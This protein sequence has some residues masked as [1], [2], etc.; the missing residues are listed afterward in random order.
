MTRSKKKYIELTN[1]ILNGLNYDD[2][3]AVTIAEGGAMGDP[4]AIEIVNSNL[5]I[6]HTHFREIDN[7]L[8]QEKI[9][10]IKNLQIAFGEIDGLSKDWAGLYAGYGNYLFVRPEYKKPILEYINK[11]YGDT[12]MPITVE[13]YSHWYD[14]IKKSHN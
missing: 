6:Y 5:D 13:L 12:G 9:P 11:K 4:G 10:F 7:N 3:I 8:L 14:A 2:L 1:D